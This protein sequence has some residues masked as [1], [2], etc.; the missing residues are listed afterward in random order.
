MGAELKYY[1]SFGQQHIHPETGDALK[2]YW[3]EVIM[4]DDSS[5]LS[6]MDVSILKEKARKIMFT[7][8]GKKWSMQYEENQFNRDYFP[9]GCYQKLY[10]PLPDEIEIYV[11][12]KFAVGDIVMLKANNDPS[13]R[14]KYRVVRVENDERPETGFQK[15]YVLVNYQEIYHFASILEKVEM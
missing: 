15:V 3:V 1:F 4:H 5:K 12:N 2:D 13:L 10:H 6:S 14:T 8:Y 9:K 11:G 7:R